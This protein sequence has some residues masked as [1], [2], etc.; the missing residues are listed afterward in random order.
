VA[1]CIIILRTVTLASSNSAFPEVGGY[2]EICR[3]FLVSILTLIKN[4]FL[5][6]FNFAS[7]GEKRNFGK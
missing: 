6:V 5:R 3:S 1:A 2:T 7:V 4:L